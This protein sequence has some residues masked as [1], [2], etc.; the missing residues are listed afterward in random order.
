[1]FP[2]ADRSKEQSFDQIDTVRMK[3][4]R[5][6]ADCKGCDHR[7]DEREEAARTSQVGFVIGVA[8]GK[9]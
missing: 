9:C 4:N 3:R 8:A 6:R 5:P 7:N 1:M 2:E